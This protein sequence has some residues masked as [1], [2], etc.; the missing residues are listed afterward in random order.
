MISEET[1]G[2]GISGGEQAAMA[3]VPAERRPQRTPTDIRRVFLAPSQEEAVPRVASLRGF[4]RPQASPA[5]GILELGLAITGLG[6]L[7][8]ML[9]HMGLLS[10]LLLGEKTMNG[11]ASFLGRYYLRQVVTPVLVVVI[12]AHVVLALRKVPSSLQ[13]QRLLLE[14]GRAMLHLDTLTWGLQMV[15]GLTLAGL[16]SIH[17]WVVLND[18]PTRAAKSAARV[19]E[20][21]LWFFTPLVVAVFIH[22]FIGLY[23]ICVKWG[24]SRGW[25]LRGAVVALTAVAF[26]MAA[27]I[28]AVLYRLEGGS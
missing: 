25:P 19:Q 17:L 9:L 5:S 16:V 10:S 6:L 3:S 20:Q 8:F 28:T 24:V 14:R 13:Q 26:G 21:Y 1:P 22:M 23:R 27:V 7:T 11:L 4:A 2:F 15:T 12:I 18:L